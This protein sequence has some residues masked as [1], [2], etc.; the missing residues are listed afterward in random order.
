MVR[1]DND[2][3]HKEELVGA[4]SV[5]GDLAVHERVAEAGDV[6]GGFPDFRVHDDGSLDADD[7]VAA[8]D[9]VVPPAVA[10][11]LLELH[12][13]GAVVEKAV[14]SAVDFGGLENEAAAFRERNDGFHEVRGL[15][16][17]GHKGDGLAERIAGVNAA[18]GLSLAV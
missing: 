17:S 14:E 13:E 6:A 16:L 12:A 3:R 1:F 15:G 5:F 4:V 11:V 7:V 2:Y 9:H 18:V 10:D 8:A